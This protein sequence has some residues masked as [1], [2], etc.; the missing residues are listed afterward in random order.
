MLKHFVVR[1]SILCTPWKGLDI[2]C[3][4]LQFQADL[5]SFTTWRP[6]FFF[7]ITLIPPM[8][9]GLT[10]RVASLSVQGEDKPLIH[11]HFSTW[12]CACFA[13]CVCLHVCLV[14]YHQSSSFVHRLHYVEAVYSGNE[15]YHGAK[16]KKPRDI[17]GSI[18]VARY[19]HVFSY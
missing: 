17:G 13:C 12:P 15:P 18:M 14:S 19:F 3:S 9:N 10:S 4:M 6:Q 16:D 1:K 11:C 8:V 2:G 5:I 7:L